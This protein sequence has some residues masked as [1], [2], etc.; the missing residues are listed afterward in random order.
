MLDQAFFVQE[1]SRLGC[2][3]KLTED[4]EGLVVQLALVD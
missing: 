2:Q 1:N 3:I 4:L